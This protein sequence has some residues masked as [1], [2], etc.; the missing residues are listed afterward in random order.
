MDICWDLC[1]WHPLL[2]IGL[3]EAPALC[4]LLN[5]HSLCHGGPI[6]SDGRWSMGENSAIAPQ[7]RN[8]RMP[9]AACDTDP[10]CLAQNSTA[11]HLTHNF[12]VN[13]TTL[14]LRLLRVRFG[15]CVELCFSRFPDIG[16]SKW[17]GKHVPWWRKPCHQILKDLQ[18]E[19]INMEASMLSVCDTEI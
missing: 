7:D 17:R 12:D 8:E 13:A 3:L 9:P 16:K 15:R 2:G 14:H 6:V 5:L 19:T 10:T 4:Q 18:R 11:W 1:Y